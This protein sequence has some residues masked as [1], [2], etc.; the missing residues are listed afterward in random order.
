[1]MSSEERQER[2]LRAAFLRVCQDKRVAALS[3]QRSLE[4]LLIEEDDPR[5]IRES[6]TEAVLDDMEDLKRALW[7]WK[8][9]EPLIGD[10]PDGEGSD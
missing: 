7:T 2:R 6:V 5:G 4:T 1:M 9:L 8:A 10:A 3:L